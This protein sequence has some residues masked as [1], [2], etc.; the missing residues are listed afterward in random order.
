M[1]GPGVVTRKVGRDRRLPS[2]RALREKRARR[3]RGRVQKAAPAVR[4]RHPGSW[5][6]ADS[7]PADA[8]TELVSL[9]ERLDRLRAAR[10]KPKPQ[11][12]NLGPKLSVA[13]P[14]IVTPGGTNF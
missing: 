7:L 9:A 10:S 14:V 3:R 5:T 8:S 13:G 1:R 6:F 11:I 2:P 4:V 12:P